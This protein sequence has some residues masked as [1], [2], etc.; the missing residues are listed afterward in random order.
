MLLS[1]VSFEHVSFTVVPSNSFASPTNRNGDYSS[2]NNGERRRSDTSIAGSF[3]EEVTPQE[4]L[5]G[6]FPPDRY[7]HGDEMPH[8]ARSMREEY[9]SVAGESHRGYPQEIYS[10]DLPTLVILPVQQD[11]LSHCRSPHCIGVQGAGVPHINGVYLLAND[12]SSTLEGD[13]APS[14]PLYFKDSPPTMLEDDRYYG[15]QSSSL[16]LYVIAS[17]VSILKFL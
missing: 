17:H 2:S 4:D 10:T 7:Y 3:F 5:N 9:H 6:S 15:E 11:Q 8:A 16:G 13:G 12:A 1:P 14:S